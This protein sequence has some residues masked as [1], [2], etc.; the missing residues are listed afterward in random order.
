MDFG[1][2]AFDYAACSPY[3]EKVDYSNDV[4]IHDVTPHAIWRIR[5]ELSD[6]RPCGCIFVEHL[7]VHITPLNCRGW[8]D[9]YSM[10]SLGIYAHVSVAVPRQV[11]I[12]DSLGITKDRAEVCRKNNH[13]LSMRKGKQTAQQTKALV[14]VNKPGIL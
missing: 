6:L 11:R 1:D 4:D 2:D 3:G 5:D 9:I 7:V 8:I 12:L 10:H 13:L 14:R